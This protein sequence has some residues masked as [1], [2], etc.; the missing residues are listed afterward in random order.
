[1]EKKSEKKSKVYSHSR[2]WLYENCPEAFKIKYIDKKFPE[3]PKSI[4]AFLGGMVHESLEW[5]YNEIK[6]K[7][8]GSVE[9]DDLVKH[10]A[11]NWKDNFS[12]ELRIKGGTAEDYFNKGIKFLVDYYEMNKPFSD[13][14][15]EIEKRFF[16][17]LDD[18]EKYKITGYIDRIVFNSK[19]GEYEVHDYKTNNWLKSQEELDSDRQLAFYNLG[20]KDLFG[21]QIKVK[22]LWH[23]LAHNRTL[24]SRRT[25]SELDELKKETLALIKKIE[26][27]TEWPA[28]GK[29]FCD[30]CEFKRLNSLEN[31]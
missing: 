6:E 13:N 17:D 5:L 21:K 20:L 24:V 14:T 7:G 29:K 18:E 9:L 1:M 31:Y 11:N 28:C 30:W 22:L 10:L 15:V 25:D 2:L 27:T 3:L 26:S 16:F 4:E 19:S 23:F 12:S 8:S